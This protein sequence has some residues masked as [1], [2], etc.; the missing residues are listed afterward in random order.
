MISSTIQNLY[1]KYRSKGLLVDS[2]LLLVYFIGQ[3][4]RAL[5][6]KYERTRAFDDDSFFLL[7]NF[8]RSFKKIVTTPNILTEVSNLSNKLKGDMR[9]AYFDSLVRQ[10]DLTEECYLRSSE[11]S[12]DP[13]FNKL[14]LTDISVMHASRNL[15]LVLTDDFL[16]SNYLTKQGQAAV[17]FNHLRQ[18]SW[19]TEKKG[20]RFI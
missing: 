18:I 5:L 11:L 13:Y 19:G 4:D 2:N 8:I 16:L 12:R 10:V 14:G 1:E 15:Y 17:N 20:D 6:S 9:L 7:V 3:Y